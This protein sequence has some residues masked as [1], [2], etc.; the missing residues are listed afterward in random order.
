MVLYAKN[1]NADGKVNEERFK[2]LV[3]LLPQVVFEADIT[4]R[5]TYANEIAFIQFGY[6]HEDFEKGIH[7]FQTIH[8]S[9]REYA[10]SNVEKLLQGKKKNSTEYLFV[11]KSGKAFPGII[12][13]VPIIENSI[14]AGFRG[15]IVDITERVE[16]ENKFR[17]QEARFKLLA[18]ATFEAIII[19][20]F[21]KIID[22][23]QSALD[24]LKF[25]REEM[26]SLTLENLIPEKSDKEL[27]YQKIQDNSEQS[28]EVK[29]LTK[30]K[31]LKDVEIKSRVLEIEGGFVRFSAIRD[32]SEQKRI[33]RESKHR[34]E[35]E[36]LLTEISA[37]FLTNTFEG[38]ETGIFQSI[39]EICLHNKLNA[40]YL[41]IRKE[42]G[43]E[44]KASWSDGQ[45]SDFDKFSAHVNE[46]P[47]YRLNRFRKSQA[48]IINSTAEIHQ[49]APDFKENLENYGINSLIEIPAV[50]EEDLSGVLCFLS[51]STR[52]GWNEYEVKF[53]Q[54]ITQIF[55]S[56]LEREKSRK[57]LIKSESKFRSIFNNTSFGI[58]QI[59]QNGEIIL[60]NPSL[61]N[62]LGF[63]PDEFISPKDFSSFFSDNFDFTFLRNN[64]K[65]TGSIKDMETVM[66]RRDGRKISVNISAE[67]I[68]LKNDIL[69]IEGS[70][71]DIT[72]LK[73]VQEN[74][75]L[76]KN[77]AEKSDKLKSE[78]LAQMSHEIRTPINTILSFAWLLKS[79]L[80]ENLSDDLMQSF[81]IM[82]RSG[83]RIIRTIDLILNMS[84]IQTGTYEYTPERFDLF[85]NIIEDLIMEQY[86]YAMDKGIFLNASKKCDAAIIN[87]DLY[88]VGQIFTNLIHNAIKYTDKGSIEV[89]VEKDSE[90]KVLGVVSDTGIGI[91]EEYLPNLFRPFT[92]EEMG[93]TRKYEGN[94]L[95]L[96]LVR[97]Y[98]NI[99]NAEISVDSKKGIGTKFIVKFN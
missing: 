13:V 45:I 82:N 26:F 37:R 97:E 23:N 2:V 16:A 68:N 47:E 15:I 49:E 85:E 54:M 52:K 43:F 56:V 62:I 41:L 95:G 4:G 24:L 96:A 64:L 11:T 74:L 55:V 84:Q 79:E 59:T 36:S 14:P 89:W 57:E 12:Y 67:L 72:E 27:V 8:P 76:A 3:D 38:A 51:K 48:V 90:G 69:L 71:E 20:K 80:K 66:V 73:Q 18:D 40:G 50:S 86:K 35:F 83:D 28:F 99:N 6:S 39:R 77:Q 1:E 19:T 46:I 33:E 78:F 88:S 44:L 5:L 32:I 81:S 29:I 9:Q 53:L 7:V 60:S 65:T 17:E 21:G 93:Y 98:C 31:E 22:F 70:V 30:D 34:S 42:H 91:S 94:G 87:A 92:Q 63:K 75:I 61:R 10:K 58:F 25:N